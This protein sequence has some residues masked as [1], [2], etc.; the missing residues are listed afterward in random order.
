LALLLGTAARRADVVRLGRQ[1]IRGGL[2][3]M[4][5][6]KTGKQMT[7][8]VTTE[9]PEAINAATPADHLVFL[10]NEFGKAF[11]PEAFTKWFVRQCE[12]AGLKRL[13]PHGLRKASCRRLA[14]AGCSA[15]EIA[16]ISSHASLAEVQ[17]YTRAAD[18]TRMARNAMERLRRT[19]QQR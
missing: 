2:V 14:E 12:R 4:M 11:S 6:Q 17:R 15:H 19:E 1:N 7:I 10:V 5:Q 3:H 9:L 16:A 18:Q 8:P 13:S